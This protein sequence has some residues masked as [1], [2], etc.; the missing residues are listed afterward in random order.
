M[1]DQFMF[2]P[3]NPFPNDKFDSSKL[4]ELAD[5]NFKLEEN[6]VGVMGKDKKNTAEQG[7]IARYEQFFLFPQ[8]FLPIWI[9]FCHF[10]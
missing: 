7:E 3:F 1:L 8:C 10:C 6:G 5:N 2:C 9:T 4:K